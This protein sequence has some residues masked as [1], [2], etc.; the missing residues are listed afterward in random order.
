MD[1]GQKMGAMLVGLEV[2]ANL[3]GRCAIYETLYLGNGTMS[4]VKFEEAIVELYARI[5]LLGP[6]RTVLL[7]KYR[8]CVIRCSKYR[9]MEEIELELMFWAVRVAFSEFDT[10]QVSLLDEV[11]KQEVL[12]LKIVDL[13]EAERRPANSFIVISYKC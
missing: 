4:A 1:D 2:I 11:D 7:Q 6:S 9:N 12:F 5:L 10:T 8:S 13:A 3:M